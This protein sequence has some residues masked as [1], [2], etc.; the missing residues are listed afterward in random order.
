MIQFDNNG[1]LKPAASIE[2]DLKILETTFTFNPHRQQLFEQYLSYLKELKSI[3][4][5][6]FE[7]IRLSKYTSGRSVLP[8]MW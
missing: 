1:Y 7:R 4:D 6:P 3:I 5:A 2:V 8:D